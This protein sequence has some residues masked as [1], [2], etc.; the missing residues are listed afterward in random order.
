MAQKGKRANI[1]GDNLSFRKIKNE[2]IRIITGN[3]QFSRDS[4]IF[5]CDSAVQYPNGI[6]K[7][8]KSVR[9]N[10]GDSLK[11]T[12]GDSLY[13][14]DAKGKARVIGKKLILTDSKMV[15]ETNKLYYNMTDEI[16]YYL[17]SAYI[18]DKENT[19]HSIKGYYYGATKN[20]HFKQRVRLIN[21][22]YDVKTDTLIYN[23]QTENSKFVGPTNIL[24]AQGDKLYC[25]EGLFLTKQNKVRLGKNTKL[26]TESQELW[27]DSIIYNAKTGEGLALKRAKLI[28][29]T[30]NIVVEGNYGKY[31]RLNN[32]F[33][34]S[35]SV[36]FTNYMQNDTLHLTSDT[37]E[38]KSDSNGNNF[39]IAY[40][41][42]RIFSNAYQAVCD[43]M[44]Y[45]GIDSTMDF[46]G[47]PVFWME[48]FQITAKDIKAWIK[49]SKLDKVRLYDQALMA[50]QHDD[51]RFDQMQGDSMLAV[52]KL[53][54]LSK[55]FIHSNCTS[56]YYAFDED[57]A[58]IGTN[59]ITAK[60]GQIRFADGKLSHLSFAQDPEANMFPAKDVDPRDFILEGFMWRGNERPLN[61]LSLFSALKL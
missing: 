32:E 36:L 18:K 38:L 20:L 10:K 8:Y 13:Y 59:K 40:H 48:D 19:I 6:I 28:D 14:S 44:H 51:D 27:G 45:S 1:S 42:V 33:L 53:G 31:N 30:Q 23:T 22:D 43:S 34:V 24:M 11:L 47:A 39:I 61:I 46:K 21:K 54:D 5:K 60:S 29:T 7:A 57:T 25:E 52:F 15:M 55:V 26:F 50:K 37:L 9:F 41:H 4:V 3:V 2:R 16:V 56:I 17:D 49:N 12:G 35:D 58:A